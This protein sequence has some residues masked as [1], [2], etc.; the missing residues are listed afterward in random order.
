[1]AALLKPVLA[2]FHSDA[3]EVSSAGNAVMQMESRDE[4]IIHAAV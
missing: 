1:L 2:N 3:E 4:D